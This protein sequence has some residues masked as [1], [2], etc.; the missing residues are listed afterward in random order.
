MKRWP[1]IIAIIALVG[2][3]G[4]GLVKVRFNAEILDLFPKELPEISS[5]KLYQQ[6][7]QGRDKLVVTLTAP[8]AWA[9]DPEREEKLLSASRSLREHLL[10]TRGHHF[11]RV[12]AEPPWTG[13][14]PDAA[15]LL[16]Y[17]WLNQAPGD[18]T[19]LA[20]RTEGAAREEKIAQSIQN[21]SSMNPEE[22]GR[23][24]Y[25][26]LGFLELPGQ[27]PWASQ[28]Q[29]PDPFVSGGGNM[30]VLLAYLENKQG[31]HNYDEGKA[32]LAEL[33]G[34]M[35]GWQHENPAFKDLTIGL[36]GNPVFVAE[37][38]TSMMRDLRGSLGIATVLIA[39]LFLIVFR[40]ISLLILLQAMLG[41]VLL[42]TFGAGGWLF[43]D[44]N[45]IS[46]GFG[47]ILLGLV[48]D[49]GLVLYAEISRFPTLT[50][51]EMRQ[52][53][54]SSVWSA[55]LTTA[56]IFGVLYWSS[57]RGVSQLGALV[58]LG[59]LFG[60]SIMLY[61]FV[62]LWVI[63]QR[64]WFKQGHKAEEAVHTLGRFSLSKRGAL[65]ITA[66]L[67]LSVAGV[68]GFLRFPSI[69]GSTKVMEPSN[70]P[71]FKVLESMQKEFGGGK[72]SI[73]ALFHAPTLE[74][75]LKQLHE[76]QPRLESARE[77]GLVTG[78]NLPLGLLPN[79]GHQD[80]NL[81]TAKTLSARWPEIKASLESAGYEGAALVLTERLLADFGTLAE[82]GP[83]PVWPRNEIS[84]WALEQIISRPAEPGAEYVTL[85]SFHPAPGKSADQ[86]R[87]AMPGLELLFT[88]WK[89]MGPNMLKIVKED[90]TRHILIIG[91]V[92]LVMLWLVFRRFSEVL[93][94]LGSLAFS[95]LILLAV[96]RLAGLEWNLM[97]LMAVPL[98]IGTGI[99]HS[100]HL[101]IA[102]QRHDGSLRETFRSIGMALLLCGVTNMIGFASLLDA[103]SS[104]LVSLG[105]VCTLGVGISAVVSVFLLP[106]WWQLA[107]PKEVLAEEKL[108][109]AAA[110]SE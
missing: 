49:Y 4:A 97:N 66:I 62:P 79:P 12:L 11:R 16:A 78:Y 109:A 71:A 17:Y 89:Y 33:H 24:S 84:T 86:L 98:M 106:A 54:A 34:E 40:R 85:G 95:M 2:F 19:A 44:I 57:F 35:A 107:H 41:L 96:M 51:R 74:G 22:V 47:A 31:F 72:E 108:P 53:V 27:G 77:A 101:Q 58:A 30:R 92:L 61:I 37:I 63:W 42:A 56:A 52:K 82:S 29:N 3:L 75:V 65:A 20:A 102:L 103:S 7:F 25:D 91:V 50:V 55:A 43:G 68:L 70:S 64:R 100:I 88:S 73:Y 87:A 10:K 94:S 83:A 48:A 59:I 14:N 76:A 26:P 8:A 32:W 46:L 45:A 69:N 80:A 81:A 90:L 1:W 23:A 6:N 39:L 93:L 105:L 15:E 9:E 21:L 5:L 99:D 104:G 67:A 110:G 28:Q 13:F 36:T 60:G 18:F 38:S